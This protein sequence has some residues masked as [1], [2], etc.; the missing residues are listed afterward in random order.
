MENLSDEQLRLIF[1][2]FNRF[3]LLLWKLGLA[4]WG[5]GTEFGGYIMVLN[6]TGRKSGLKRQT[7]INYAEIDGD[8]YCTAAFGSRADWYLNIMANPLVELWLPDSRWAGE[9]EDA[10]EMPDG[11]YLLRQV[12]I[13]SGFAGPLFGVNPKQ[14]SDEQFA[15]LLESYKLVRIR[16]TAPVTGP[17]GPGEL[18][19]IWPLTTLVL[20]I[21][22]MMKGKRRRRS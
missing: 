13:A 19:W 1:R 18:A 21:K 8:I 22:L 3:M 17:G 15:E 4:K 7:P 5:N 11:P 2:A 14:M 20:L 6:H 16:R 9:A 12:I 10:S